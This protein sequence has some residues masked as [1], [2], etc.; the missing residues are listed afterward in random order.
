LSIQGREPPL[1]DQTLAT[2]MKPV[3]RLQEKVYGV[4][5]VLAAEERVVIVDKLEMES[6]ALEQQP[7][8]VANLHRA[9]E[10][11]IDS[12]IP[13]S[14]LVKECDAL[15]GLSFLS[16][17][18]AIVDCRGPSLFVRKEAPDAVF[19]KDFEQ[20]LRR[21]GFVPV[22]LVFV[23]QSLYV[24]GAINNRPANFLLDTGGGV[25][26]VDA[27]QADALGLGVREKIMMSVDARRQ[28][29]GHVFRD[30]PVAPSRGLRP[31]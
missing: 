8:V 18:H 30:R 20:S 23:H 10:A 7:A 19:L 16:Q 5:G 28:E 25:T 2:G 29:E 17:N 26:T 14:P 9:R 22:P 21:G 12:L 1:L 6:V 31:R 24:A 27:N 11:R 15:L 13:R 3:E 4:F